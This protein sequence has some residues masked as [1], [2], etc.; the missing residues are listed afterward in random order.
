MLFSLLTQ[1]VG[2]SMSRNMSDSVL[3]KRDEQRPAPQGK[4]TS[5]SLPAISVAGQTQ[6]VFMQLLRMKIILV[7]G[8]PTLLEILIPLLASGIHI[9]GQKVT[10]DL[11]PFHERMEECFTQLRAKVESHFYKA[12]KVQNFT[13]S[14]PV[15]KGPKNPENEF[16]NMIFIHRGKEYERREDFELQ[17]MTQFPSAEKLKT[18]SPP[19]DDIKNSPGQYVGGGNRA[20]QGAGSAVRERAVRLRDAERQPGESRD[21]RKGSEGEERRV[22]ERTGRERR[23]GREGEEWEVVGGRG[24]GGGEG[25]EERRGGTPRG[26][27]ERQGG[28][29]RERR[30]E[31]RTGRERRWGDGEERKAEEMKG[32]EEGKEVGGV[33][34]LHKLR[35]LHLCYENYTEAAFTLLL[36]AKLLKNFYKEIDRQEMYIR[37]L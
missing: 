13:Y 21:E 18:T 33:R 31:E 4:T 6:R 17:L 2:A 28:E 37:R 26:D 3:D 29:A 11:K 24:G 20:V 9:H 34:Y 25:G 30:V 23:W 10:G 1:D 32:R 35:D 19:G 16:A 12:N 15:R 22:K 8:G 36:H 14:R 7:D 5:S 27:A